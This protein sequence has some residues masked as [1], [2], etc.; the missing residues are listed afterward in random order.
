MCEK[1]DKKSIPRPRLFARLRV[2]GRSRERQRASDMGPSLTKKVDRWSA[3]CCLLVGRGSVFKRER[4]R[5][6]GACQSRV[7]AGMVRNGSWEH[8]TALLREPDG[9]NFWFLLAYAYA[10]ASERDPS[11]VVVLTFSFH[12]S[13]RLRGWRSQARVG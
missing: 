5:L 10:S 13:V 7:G 3:P 4:W 6:G 2:R 11:L 8:V 1:V 9:M 12:P